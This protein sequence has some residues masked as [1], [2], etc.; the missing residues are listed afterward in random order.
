MVADVSCLLLRLRMVTAY[1]WFLARDPSP[2]YN[3]KDV[4]YICF[5]VFIAIAGFE[6]EFK[7]ANIIAFII[8]SE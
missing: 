6:I 3:W 7:K 8:L 2:M 4:H 1:V 5:D